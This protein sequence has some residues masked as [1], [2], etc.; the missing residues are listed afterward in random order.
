MASMVDC[1]DGT[2]TSK[3]TLKEIDSILRDVFGVYCANEKSLAGILR[4]RGK[5][6][7]KTST[8]KFDY[9]SHYLTGMSATELSI[10]AGSC[11]ASARAWIE[12]YEIERVTIPRDGN[13][14]LVLHCK[15][16]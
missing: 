9:E 12:R 14:H 10:A 5:N 6:F 4:S 15:W 8:R 3:M 7:I 13:A 1:L 16:S 2:D 11:Q